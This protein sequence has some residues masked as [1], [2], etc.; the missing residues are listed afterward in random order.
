MTTILPKSSAKLQNAALTALC[1]GLA[2]MGFV[3]LN[4]YF[5]WSSQKLFYA[6]SSLLLIATF[7]LCWRLFSFSGSRITL[8]LGFCLFLIYLSLLPKTDEG[9]TRWFLLIPFI[10]SLLAVRHAELERAFGQFYWLFSISLIPGMVLWF[11]TAFGF[12]VKFVWITPPSETIQRGIIDYFSIPGAVV[13]PSNAQMLPN[14]GVIFRLCGVYDEP[15]TVG[16]IAALF[17]AASKFRLRDFRGAIAFMA[18]LMSFSVAFA[19]L[20]TLGL[21]AT[22]LTKQRWSLLPF[23]L[24]TALMGGVVTGFVPLKYD[25]N[26][27]PNIAIIEKAVN[28]TVQNENSVVSDENYKTKL[29]KEKHSTPDSFGLHDKT[30]LRFS[31]VFDN[32]AQPKMRDLFENYLQSSASTILLGIASDASNMTGGSSIWYMILTNYGAI[33]FI[34]LFLLFLFPPLLFLRKYGFSMLVIIFCSLF[35]MSFYQRPVIW[36]PAQ[37]LLYIA[38]VFCFREALKSANIQSS[39]YVRQ[40]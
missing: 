13:L 17:L 29:L 32:R 19:I 27:K 11:W 23:A 9:F 30:R 8:M 25:V 6:A 28:P 18:G 12:P 20:V 5:M 26:V 31:D 4:P 33:G 36:L 2:F 24:L 15:G 16:T 14:G 37:L 35:L 40:S 10:I 1:F 22:A 3:S 38:G 7:P 21:V 34:W 39:G